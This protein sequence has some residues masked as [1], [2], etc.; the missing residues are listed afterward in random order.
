MAVHALDVE[1]RDVTPYALG[2]LL[3]APAPAALVEASLSDGLGGVLTLGVL[4]ASHV[5]TATV[6]GHHLTEQ[7]SCDA[8]AGGGREL[9]QRTRV[10]GYALVTRIAGMTGPELEQVAAR[11]RAAARGSDSWLCA[12]F[13]GF[14][15]A[16][17]V[18]RASPL[19]AGGW[20]WASWHLYPGDRAGSVV[21]TRSSW[22]PR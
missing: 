8:V 20:S 3:H 9:P 10:G 6:P 7:I 15:G 18:I 12:E 11:L 2:L 5:V 22:V 14:A 16:M 1:P 4:G 17:T 13:P 19:A 21:R